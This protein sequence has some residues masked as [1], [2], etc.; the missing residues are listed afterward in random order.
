ME[1]AL[2]LACGEE[3]NSAWIPCPKCDFEPVD[4]Q[5]RARHYWVAERCRE[6]ARLERIQVA[7]RAGE[8]PVFDEE[9][10]ARIVEDL[11]QESLVGAAAFGLVIGFLPILALVSLLLAFA[12]LLGRI[13]P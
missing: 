11:G 12:W 2:C 10:V 9:E 5:D 8:E 3:K 4:I 7:V 13:G 1:R 6:P